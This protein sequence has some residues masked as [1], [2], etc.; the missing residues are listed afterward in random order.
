MPAGPKVPRAGLLVQCTVPQV[1][2][3]EP[4]SFKFETLRMVVKHERVNKDEIREEMLNLRGVKPPTW[5]RLRYSLYSGR[6]RSTQQQPQ[7]GTGL[8][9]YR[10]IVK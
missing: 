9:G 8:N 10:R 1:D 2:S 6:P 5:H 4:I 3:A 7:F